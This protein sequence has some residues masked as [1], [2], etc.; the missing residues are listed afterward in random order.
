M[1]TIKL[2]TENTDAVIRGLEKKHFKGA[3]ESIDK[4]LELN[5]KRRI[6]QNQ[7]DKNLAEVNAT[8]KSIGQLMKEGKKEE[9]EAAK[10][11]VSEIK[12]VSKALQVE[13]DQAAEE[14]Q[15]LLYTIPNVPYD[16]VPEG[17]SAED[18]VVE[19]MG[20]MET[21]LPKNALPHWELAKKYDLIDFDLGVKITG[22]GFP[23]Y[24]GQGARL[25]RALIN[26]FLDE[27]R[28]AGYLEI[29]PPTVV[30]SASGYGTGQLPDKEGQMYHCEVDD[31]Y[32]I[33][34]AEVP[35]TNIY[36]DVILDEKQLPIKNCAYT[37]CFRREA[38]SYGKDVRGLNRLHEFSKVEL[39]RIDKPEHS[40]QSHQE[41]LNH[42]EGLLQKLE[43][44]YRILRLCGGDMSFTAALCF[45]F[46]V[47]SEAQQRW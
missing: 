2:I 15:N 1:L 10:K 46:E 11:H 24:K 18:N 33:P 32:L 36:R 44:P 38:G 17:T 41:M 3:K 19:K 8:S 22:A 34:T 25:Q 35:V 7:L 9:A 43:L 29:M 21:E 28:D 27:A 47:Y 26:F 42:V 5:D 30:N 20:G 37:Q 31:L 39:V 13:M 16:E 6:A 4:V 12:E 23:V 14:L 40:K 45:D